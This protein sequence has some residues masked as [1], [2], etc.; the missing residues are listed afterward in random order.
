VRA[1]SWRIR[2][3]G[4]VWLIFEPGWA[5]TAISWAPTH[6]AAVELL[7]VL[8]LSNVTTKRECRWR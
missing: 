1:T 5:I 8:Q 6:P 7:A 3:V 4:A 2:K